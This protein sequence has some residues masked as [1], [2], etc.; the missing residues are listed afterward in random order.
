VLICSP[1]APSRGTLLELAIWSVP[2]EC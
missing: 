2:F 1:S